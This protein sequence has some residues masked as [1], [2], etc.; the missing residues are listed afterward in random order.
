MK[1]IYQYIRNCHSIGASM[2]KS[3]LWVLLAVAAMGLSSCEDWFNIKP[4]AELVSEDFWQSKS[5]VESSVAACYRAMLEPGFMERVI[6]WGEARSDNALAGSMT[7]ED[8]SNIMEANIDASNGYTSWGS[9]YSVI[10]NCNTVIENAPMVLERD[11]NFRRGELNA[12]LAEVKAIRA[13]CYFYLVRTF[14]DVPFITQAYTDDTREF[15]VE[16]TDGDELID[17][18]LEDLETIAEN[19]ARAEFSSVA[20]TKGR[21]TQK[22]LWTLMADMYLWRNN[23]D[24]CIEYCQK[25]QN[26]S[27]NPLQLESTS[28]Y[29]R[30]VFGTGN[31]TESIFE[32]QFT[33]ETP[34]YVVNEMYGTSGGRSYNNHLSSADFRNGTISLFIDK[35]AD[36][37]LYDA[38]FSAGSSGLVP[39]KK[40]ISY[41]SETSNVMSGVTARDYID[42]SNNQHWIFYRLSD[43]YLMEAEARVER[44]G[45]DG[46]LVKAAE[47]LNHTYD[48]ANPSKGMG[49]LNLSSASQEQLR[50]A[51]FNERQRE[52][53][54]EGKRYF[55]ILRRIRREGNLNSIVSTY[56]MPKY[57][58]LDQSTVQT[59]LN[60]LNALYMPIHKDEL[61]ANKLLKQNPFYEKSSDIVKE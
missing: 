41:R 49:S 3:A 52:L 45:A 51:V 30:N 2:K 42:N 9:V 5:D 16:Q 39:I 40:Y 17:Q 24:K 33:S 57:A 18:L 1:R 36:V 28:A 14:K 12:Y 50:D 8:I 43:V 37:R 10:N 54:F 22:A 48:R 23:Y 44:N 21:I 7:S 26:T 35:N 59:K 27:T 56:L 53:M 4:D 61:K 58:N 29:N 6:V 25:V 46:D 20:D 32:L 34:N 11:P 19:N 38:L 55:D 13:L 15:S 60:T 31:S 47:L